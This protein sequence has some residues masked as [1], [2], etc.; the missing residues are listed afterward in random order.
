MRY[1]DQ[2]SAI[3]WAVY[4]VFMDTIWLYYLGI[5]LRHYVDPEWQFF[6]GTE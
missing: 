4:A 6:L 3:M 5:V 1:T 2:Y